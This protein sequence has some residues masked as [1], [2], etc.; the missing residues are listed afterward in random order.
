MAVCK[1]MLKTIAL[2]GIP[3][4]ECLQQVNR[5]IHLESVASMFV[6]VFYGILDLSSGEVA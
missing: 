2:K 6:T 5:I 1:T 3:P 4:E